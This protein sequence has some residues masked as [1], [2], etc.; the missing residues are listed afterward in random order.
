LGESVAPLGDLDGDGIGDVAV[1]ASGWDSPD[2]Q[3]GGVWILFLRRD[4]TIANAR[5]LGGQPALQEAG[6]GAGY[7]LGSSLA[8]LGD[9]DRDGFPEIAI[10]QDP[11]FD[12]G[13]KLGRSVHIVSLGRSGQVRWSRR[14]H[15]RTE[16]FGQHTW[17]GDALAGIGDVDAD[18]VND[19]AISNTYDDDGGES[20]GAVW[21]VFL[22]KDGSTKAK[23]KISAW[24]GNFTGVLRDRS[25]FGYALA[26]PGDLDGDGKRD[27]LVTGGGGVWTLFL[28]E[29][30]M[31]RRHSFLTVGEAR[32]GMPRNVGSSIAPSSA[33]VKNGALGIALGG[34]FTGDGGMPKDSGVWFVKLSADGSVTAW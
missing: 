13:W 26:G 18:G 29:K 25:L 7:G 28:D 14:L 23:Q 2:D 20:R 4:G 24:Q 15:D 3:R 27:L 33:G 6:V 31:V 10:A 32:P 1:G 17:F 5:E 8:N 11:Q 9:L 16:G 21:I 30:G 12:L 19:I 34:M 22:N